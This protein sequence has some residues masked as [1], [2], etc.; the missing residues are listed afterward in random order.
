MPVWCICN[1]PDLLS[2]AMRPG[3]PTTT[4][5]LAFFSA[6][7][8]TSQHPHESECQMNFL[9]QRQFCSS[10]MMGFMKESAVITC[11]VPI[12]QIYACRNAFEYL[13]P[14]LLHPCQDVQAKA[15]HDALPAVSQCAPDLEHLS[16]ELTSTGKQKLYH[17]GST[18]SAQ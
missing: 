1:W 8:C 2:S 7:F 18:R 12:R 5:G 14:M 15:K 4:I 13:H 10:K 16:C 9:I 11:R 6:S 17:S 3:V